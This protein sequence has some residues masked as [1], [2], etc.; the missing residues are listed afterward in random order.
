MTQKAL[1]E[2][3]RRLL[4]IL[5]WLNPVVVNRDFLTRLE[6]LRRRGVDVYIGHGI[7]QQNERRHVDTHEIA[8]QRL[9]HDSLPNTCG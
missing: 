1:Q 8:L 6:S 7:E 5:P 3:S 9:W 4:I 2:A